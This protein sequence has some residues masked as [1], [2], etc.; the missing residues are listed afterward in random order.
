MTDASSREFGGDGSARIRVRVKRWRVEDTLD[1]IL[2]KCAAGDYFRELAGPP[3]PIG[4]PYVIDQPWFPGRSEPN[5]SYK[6]IWRCPICGDT[7]MGCG[8]ITTRNGATGHY[9]QFTIASGR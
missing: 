1:H 9:Q 6:S 4:S 5:Q 7:G 8:H 2:K 3:I